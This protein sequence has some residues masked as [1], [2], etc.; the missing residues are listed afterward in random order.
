LGRKHQ[1]EKLRLRN[2]RKDNPKT[3]NQRKDVRKDSPGCRRGLGHSVTK[4]GW[5][6]GISKNCARKRKDHRDHKHSIR[7]GGE[8]K[9][10]EVRERGGA[11]GGGKE[12][13][14]AAG[15]GS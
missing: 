7:G 1:G 6:P 4:S 8:L 5:G 10:E 14:E 2:E 3:Q 9:E 11:R 15:S 12:E 13:R